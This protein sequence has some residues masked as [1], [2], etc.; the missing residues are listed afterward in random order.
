M[1]TPP[2]HPF[3]ALG[4]PSAD[5]SAYDIGNLARIRWI[6]ERD[7]VVLVPRDQH[8]SIRIGIRHRRALGRDRGLEARL[9]LLDLLAQRRHPSLVERYGLRLLVGLERTH[10]LAQHEVV[11]LREIRRRDAEHLDHAGP[12]A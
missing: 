10:R 8:G 9:F 4:N 2:V 7:A 11:V 12:R 3:V 5:R 1:L 6:R